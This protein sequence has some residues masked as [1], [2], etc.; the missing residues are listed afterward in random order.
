MAEKGVPL[1][2]SEEY[3]QISGS[4]LSSFPKYRPP[5]DLFQFKESIMQL[6]PYYSKGCRLSNEQVDE[7]AILCEEGNLFVSRADHSVYSVHIVKQ[8]DLV[9]V[10]NN[11]KE[12]EVAD[13][14]VE[15][16]RQRLS[17]FFSQP[18]KAFYDLLEADVMVVTEYLWQDRYRMKL[19]LRRLWCGEYDL[20]RHSVNCL[21]LGLWL[22]DGH[23]GKEMKRKLLDDAALGFLL[24][25][26]GMT[27]IPAFI[28][29][30][31]TP[32]KPD[33]KSKIPPHVLTGAAVL[34]KLDL[35]SKTIEQAT[36]EHQERL[37]GSGYPQRSKD[38]SPVGRISAVVDSFS[39]MLQTRP[40]AAA[41]SF[42][43]AAGELSNSRQL[44]DLTFS[45]ALLKAV[46]DNQMGSLKAQEK[47]GQA[48]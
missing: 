34:R 26:V 37:D 31:N 32:L 1:N 15:A 45:G 17:D 28:L 41:K 13:I 21:F 27:K 4:I 47:T 20:V 19:F 22:L 5:L 38:L 14:C 12:S 2:I 23:E 7:V 46:I 9:L 42:A 3:Y 29:N 24:H 6:V 35:V 25:D 43:D 11:L 39:A 30:K 18:V 48:G 40:Y 44:Y 36:L 16:L 33:E 10:D 8:L